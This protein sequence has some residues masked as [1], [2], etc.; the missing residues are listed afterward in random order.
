MKDFYSELSNF[1]N[2]FGSYKTMVLST[3]LDDRVTSRTMSIVLINGIFYFQTDRNFEKCR[4]IENNP[5]ISLCIDNI[6]IE[7]ICSE[8]GA[9]VDNFEFIKV[10][11]N[12]FPNSYKLYSLLD[13]EVLYEIKPVLIKKWIYENGYP[14]TE[15]FDLK[16]KEYKKI[17]YQV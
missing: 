16:N 15:T 6:K 9:P 5:N 1:Y 3:S 12:C 13:T 17:K 7:G 11:K 2:G 14:Y 8:I 4:Q 10:Y